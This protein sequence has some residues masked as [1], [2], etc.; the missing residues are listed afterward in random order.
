MD[1]RMWIQ[2]DQKRGE[3]LKGVKVKRKQPSY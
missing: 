1:F 2:V 3:E